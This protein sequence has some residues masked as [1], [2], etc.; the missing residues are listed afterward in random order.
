MTKTQ[1]YSNAKLIFVKYVASLQIFSNYPIFL[2]YIIHLKHRKGFNWNWNIW[3]IKLNIWDWKWEF[4]D[5]KLGS[6]IENDINNEIARI[7]NKIYNHSIIEKI[8]GILYSFLV[9]G[10]KMGMKIWNKKPV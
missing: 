4:W 9:L 2:S 7:V 1:F 10:R 3:D 6:G 8:S 5:E